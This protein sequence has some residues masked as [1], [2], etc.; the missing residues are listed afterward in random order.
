MGISMD[1][2]D[3]RMLFSDATACEPAKDDPQDFDVVSIDANAMLRWL[4]GARNNERVP[5][6][7]AAQ[8]FIR[9]FVAPHAARGSTATSASNWCRFPIALHT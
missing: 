6:R 2:V 8:L 4:L 9:A 3:R 7:K 1:P 5:P